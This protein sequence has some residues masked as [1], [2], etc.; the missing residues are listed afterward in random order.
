M[1]TMDFDNDVNVASSVVSV[2]LCWEVVTAG[3]HACMRAEGS[4]KS[5]YLP[6]DLTMNLKLL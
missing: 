4:G 6:L 3:G 2:P 1:Y 5:L